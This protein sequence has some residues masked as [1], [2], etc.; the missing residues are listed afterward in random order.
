MPNP[1]SA[2]AW[3]AD[4]GATGVLLCHGFTGS[5]AS[6][7]PWGEQLAAA[8]CTVDLPRLPGHGTTWQ[9]LNLTRWD[10]WYSTVER[11]LVQLAER[12][13]TVFVM[14]LSMGGTLTLRL[15]EQ[16]PDLITGVAVVN[17]IVHSESKALRALPLLRH[18]VPSM[19]GVV[20]DIKKPGQDEVGYDRLPLQA[21]Y[22]LTQAWPDVR[23]GLGTITLP[24]LV[25][26]SSVDHVV[27][28]SNAA[29]VLAHLG[30]DDVTDVELPNSFHVATLDHDAPTIVEQSLRFIARLTPADGD[31]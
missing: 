29:Y 23:R 31:G 22:S 6:M 25:M 30:S 3:S 5:P 14:G 28:P 24:V 26:H 1:P 7:R 13:R 18:V 20:N 12:C 27:E 21:L 17:P 2:E 4:G 16:H 10:D 11:A 8:G 15:A 19:P 9:E